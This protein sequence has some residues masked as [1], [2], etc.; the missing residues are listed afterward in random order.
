MTFSLWAKFTNPTISGDHEYLFR[1]FQ[2]N[3]GGSYTNN[4]W[5]KGDSTP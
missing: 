5:I 3:G 2:D 1:F 4:I